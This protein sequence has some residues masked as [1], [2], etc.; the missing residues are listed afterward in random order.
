MVGVLR[1][2]DGNTCIWCFVA[3]N[4]SNISQPYYTVNNLM[5]DKQVHLVSFRNS[6]KGFPNS[7]HYQQEFTQL[8]EDAGMQGGPTVRIVLDVCH[9]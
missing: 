3:I 9:I 2:S 5:F 1:H 6:L 8:I 7:I 4:L